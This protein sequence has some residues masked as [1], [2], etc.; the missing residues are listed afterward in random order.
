MK[1][2]FKEVFKGEH[3]ITTGS[4]LYRKLDEH[5]FKPVA[6]EE[7]SHNIDLDT[8]VTVVDPLKWCLEHGETPAPLYYK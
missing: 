4:T 7:G 6:G 2:R 3:F 8:M 1:K 5:A